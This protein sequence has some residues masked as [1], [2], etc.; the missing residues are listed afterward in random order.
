MSTDALAS[1]LA[2]KNLGV[3]LS[4]RIQAADWQPM[5][6]LIREITRGQAGAIPRLPAGWL[7]SVDA[8]AQEYPD[9]RVSLAPA[10]S[11]SG[12][13]LETTPDW[14]DSQEKLEAW[15]RAYFKM[16]EG[17]VVFANGMREDGLRIMAAANDRA[18]WAENVYQVVKV[19]AEA[20]LRVTN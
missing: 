2:T 12:K 8:L 1:D 10:L 9:Q 17:E 5:E 4:P 18:W 6:A 14:L 16:K 20:L 11:V 15:N 19:I 13:R 3:R 7:A